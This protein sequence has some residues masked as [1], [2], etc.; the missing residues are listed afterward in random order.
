[1]PAN[2]IVH[3]EISAKD[4]AAASKFYADVFGWKIEVDPKFNYYQFAAEGGPGGG[5]NQVGE[6]FK[7]GEVI[8]YIGAEDI[9]AA[10]KKVEKAG[11]KVLLPKTE[12]PGIGWYAFF[13]DPSGTRIGL[14]DGLRGPG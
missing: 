11:G 8:P 5:F 7:A 3:I 12:I 13:A 10:L 2:P 6:N 9:D 14:Y 1:M 4:P